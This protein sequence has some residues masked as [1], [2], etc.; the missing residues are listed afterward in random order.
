MSMLAAPLV[1]GAAADAGGTA[2]SRIAAGRGS[3]PRPARAGAKVPAKTAAS[4]ASE[5]TTSGTSR[6]RATR[7]LRDE[8]GATTAQA[9][10]LLDAAPQPP[11]TLTP[12][13]PASPQSS[14]PGSS[15]PSVPKAV[16]S[17]WTAGGGAILGTLVYVLFLT[18]MRGGPA[19]VTTW[20]RAKFL[21]QTPATANLSAVTPGG[22]GANGL[23]PSGWAGQG[24]AGGAGG[25]S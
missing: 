12:D 4:R 5:L 20:F 10:D 16:S 1:E 22:N 11:A 14:S 15:L 25:R 17:A 7:T 13:P 18:Y 2:A 6:T 19:G 8:Y 9:S 23:G 24:V 21:N 3:M